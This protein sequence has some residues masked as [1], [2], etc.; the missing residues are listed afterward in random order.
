MH[1]ANKNYHHGDLKAELIRTGLKILDQ[2]GYESFSLRKVARACNVSQTAPYRHFKDKD[3]LITAIT[4]EA[5]RAFNDC[6]EET[7]ISNPDHPKQ[8]LIDMGVA[9][10]KFFTERP[11]YLRLIF[12][13]SFRDKI[14]AYCNSSQISYEGKEPFQ[15]FYETIVRYKEHYPEHPMSLEELLLYCWG[16]V[17][18]I[19]ILIA[20]KEVSFNIQPLTLARSLLEKSFAHIE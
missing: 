14:N 4:L 5:V 6:L 17:H 11:E 20:N 12:L 19:S 3:E 18:G 15:T 13:N 9:Y 8:Q 2:E 10:I 1:M 7:V 16:L